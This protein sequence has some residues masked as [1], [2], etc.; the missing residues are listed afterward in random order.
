MGLLRRL[1]TLQDGHT[2]DVLRQHRQVAGGQHIP[3]QQTAE[4][5]Q[6]AWV[7]PFG[8]LSILNYEYGQTG[9]AGVPHRIEQQFTLSARIAENVDR[10]CFRLV[11]CSHR[12]KQTE[13]RIVAVEQSGRNVSHRNVD[14]IH[15]IVGP[16]PQESPV[17]G[18]IRCLEPWDV[19][20]I[21]SPP[22][23]ILTLQLSRGGQKLPQLL[24]NLLESRCKRPCEAAD[25]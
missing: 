24:L 9:P 10:A 3:L 5:G 2:A 25:G 1:Q 16:R 17:D 15:A 21:T 8:L 12:G 6:P 19:I 20:Q 11:A 13:L 4:V 14:L 18:F 23:G 22:G 7:C